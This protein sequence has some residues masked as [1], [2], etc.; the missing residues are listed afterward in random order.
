[1]KTLREQL[2]NVSFPIFFECEA[3]Q[4]CEILE[5]KTT[6]A[7]ATALLVDFGTRKQNGYPNVAGLYVVIIKEREMVGLSMDCVKKLFNR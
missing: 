1:M 4:E 5:S 7:G 3:N 2:E 6:V